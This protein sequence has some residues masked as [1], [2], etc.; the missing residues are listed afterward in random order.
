[1]VRLNLSEGDANLLRLGAKLRHELLTGLLGSTETAESN[2]FCV[3]LPAR[4]TEPHGDR[5]K[6]WVTR[7][8]LAAPSCPRR[9]PRSPRRRQRHAR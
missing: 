4:D 8:N 9:C 2:A 7:F 6:V 1:M 5:P 3:L